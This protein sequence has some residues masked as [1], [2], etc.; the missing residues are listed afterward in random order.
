ML[1]TMA[2]GITVEYLAQISIQWR[3]KMLKLATYRTPKSQAVYMILYTIE[4]FGAYI[5]MLVAMSYS[6]K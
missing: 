5:S 3:A 4:R 6:V 1:V 2:L